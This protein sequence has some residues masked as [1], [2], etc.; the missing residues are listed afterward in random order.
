MSVIEAHIHIYHGYSV[1]ES[2]RKTAVFVVF[3]MHVPCTELWSP[4]RDITGKIHLPWQAYLIVIQNV[5]TMCFRWMQSSPA[6][7][8]CLC[9][10]HSCPSW[11]TTQTS[12][13]GCSER[14]AGQQDTVSASLWQPWT[15]YVVELGQIFWQNLTRPVYW[16]C[17]HYQF[18]AVLI[19]TIGCRHRRQLVTLGLRFGWWLK[20]KLVRGCIPTAN[21]WLYIVVPTFHVNTKV[22]QNT[23]EWLKE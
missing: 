14:R 20:N 19:L 1:T 13:W 11:I 10:P 6:S 18:L 7:L 3:V 12:L 22:S 8:L 5:I 2:V 21:S 15:R 17:I 23:C 9:C 4:Y 16:I